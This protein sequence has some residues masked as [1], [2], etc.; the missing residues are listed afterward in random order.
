VVEP[1]R[2]V[3]GVHGVHGKFVGAGLR[4]EPHAVEHRFQVGA[5]LAAQRP[6]K[7]SLPILEF[8]LDE[9]TKSGNALSFSLASGHDGT[10]PDDLCRESCRA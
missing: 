5:L 3:D 10:C 2:D 9:L 8:F 4:V 6:A 7:N 1:H